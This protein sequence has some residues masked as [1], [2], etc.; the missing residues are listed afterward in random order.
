MA[1]GLHLHTSLSL[2]HGHN[3]ASIDRQSLCGRAEERAGRGRGGEVLL[4]S[5]GQIHSHEGIH[6]L[7]DRIQYQL[8]STPE[9]QRIHFEETLDMPHSN[10]S[11]KS[12]WVTHESGM[13]FW[14][15]L[16]KVTWAGARYRGNH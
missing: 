9:L 12:F 2:Y 14:L 13:L 6:I 11:E 8:K 15:T 10:E 7:Q 5:L 3:T 16:P 1:K 4:C